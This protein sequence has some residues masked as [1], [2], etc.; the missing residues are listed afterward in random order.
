[1][2]YMVRVTGNSENKRSSKDA[3]I[4]FISE[5]LEER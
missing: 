5:K 1:M 2:D 4:N 3:N